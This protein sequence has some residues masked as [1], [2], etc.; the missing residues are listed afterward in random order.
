ML[1]TSKKLLSS[2][3]LFTFVFAFAI[4]LL[5]MI[6]SAKATPNVIPNLKNKAAL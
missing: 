1:R 2:L 3:T 4:P 5:V 6:E